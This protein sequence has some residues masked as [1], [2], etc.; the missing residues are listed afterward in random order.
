[1]H[2]G[3]KPFYFWQNLKG[4]WAKAKSHIEEKTKGEARAKLKEET[5]AGIKNQDEFIKTI[6]I[7]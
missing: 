2:L 3:F 5:R 7:S 4:D 6:I 1:M